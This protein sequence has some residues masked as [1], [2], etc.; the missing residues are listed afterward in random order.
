MTYQ[1]TTSRDYQKTCSEAARVD[2][3][4]VSA[5]PQVPH[6]QPWHL[7][8]LA[9]LPRGSR[10]LAVEVAAAEAAAEAVATVEAV[11]MKAGS[12]VLP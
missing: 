12:R 6:P 10:R 4:T 3:S 8:S 7:H 1:G 2:Y 9:G 5:H 11:G